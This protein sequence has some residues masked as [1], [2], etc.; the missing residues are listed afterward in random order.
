[1]PLRRTAATAE[2]KRLVD[3]IDALGGDG[4]LPNLAREVIEMLESEGAS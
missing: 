2:L 4:G 1:M 3:A